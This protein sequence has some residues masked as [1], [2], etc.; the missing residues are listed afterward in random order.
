MLVTFSLVAVFIVVVG[1]LANRSRDEASI[2]ADVA[3][4]LVGAG[5]SAGVGLATHVIVRGVVE[6]RTLPAYAAFLIYVVIGI[7]ALSTVPFVDSEVLLRALVQAGFGVVGAAC[8]AYLYFTWWLDKA[9]KARTRGGRLTRA[10]RRLVMLASVA[11]TLSS[12]L[13]V[14]VMR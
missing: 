10:A 14:L 3:T 2:S 7:E 5:V 11:A 6:G 9:L 1:V 13:F 4:V 8:M 12:F